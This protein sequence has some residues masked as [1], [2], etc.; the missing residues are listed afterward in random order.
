MLKDYYEMICV[1]QWKWMKKSVL[2]IWYLSQDWQLKMTEFA[3]I[4]SHIMKGE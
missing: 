1:P 2:L 3:K 4:A